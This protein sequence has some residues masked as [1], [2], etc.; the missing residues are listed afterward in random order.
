[1]DE[2]ER[3]PVTRITE[4]GR[5]ESE[6]TIVREFPLT[7]SLNNQELVTLLCTPANLKYLAVGFLF[8]EGLLKDRNEIKKIVVDDQRG[9]VWVETKEDRVVN[10]EFLSKRLITSGCGR[11]ASFYSLADIQSQAKIESQVQVS[12]QEIFSLVNGFQHHSDIYRSTHGVHSAAL[13]DK[14]NIL[15]FAEDIGRHNAIDKVFGECILKD[16]PTGDLIMVVSG[17]ISS[18]MLL[19]VVKRSIPILISI[20]APTNLGVRLANDLDMTLVGFVRGKR[21]SVY[22]GKWRITS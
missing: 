21:M 13:C 22:S 5:N 14:K 11:G 8:S 9:V 18:E 19:K 3:F 1:M 15:L 17:R 10:N 12:P 6:D 20:A 4:E 16:I 7:I 2:V